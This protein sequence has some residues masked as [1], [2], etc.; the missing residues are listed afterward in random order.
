MLIPKILTYV[1]TVIGL[2]LILV[3]AW[4]AWKRRNPA[5]ATGDDSSR[6]GPV[7]AN[8]WIRGARALFALFFVISVFMHAYWVFWADSNPRFTLAKNLDA[9]NRRLA[10]SGLKGW[11]LDRSA[12]LEN[13][14]IRYR[15]DRGIVSR[16]YPLG[17]AAVHLTGYSDFVFGSGG[18]E[19]AYNDWLTEPVS[20]YNQLVSPVPT[21]NDLTVSIDSSLQRETFALLQRT[22][23][24]AAAVVLLLPNNEVLAMA[25]TPSF[26]PAAV[27]D[28]Q[29]WLRNVDQ[30]NRA[31]QLSPLVN[32]AT[33]TMVTGGPAYYYRPGSTFKTFTAAVAL[34]SGLMNE[35]FV[36]RPEGFVAP[37]V[38]RPI[39]DFEGEV[40]GNIGFEDA[41]KFSCNQYFGQLGI[42][43]GR[44][45]LSNYARR[46]A[47]LIDPDSN[48]TRARD[49]WRINHGDGKDFNF[50]F[51]PPISR[52]N[53]SSMAD[54]YD[55]AL[56]S[57]G[58]GFTDATLIQMAL[59]AATVASQDGVLTPP[60][61]EMGVE[62]KGMVQ[63]ISPQAAAKLRVMMRSVVQSGTA[64]GPFAS[65]RQGLTAGGKTG[66]AERDLIV[67]DRDG[68]P[69]VDKIDLDGRV[70]YKYQRWTDSW[71]IGFAPADEPQIAFAVVVENGG[72]GSRAAAPLAVRLIENAASLGYIARP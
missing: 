48:A 30:A 28:E 15:A 23:R 11:V 34:D 32:R 10:E 46:L 66:T 6:P 39:R 3:L 59:L 51:A 64:A 67:Y 43:L 22:G 21:G 71:F 5:L 60:T 20:T 42:K 45:R 72:P 68:K 4:A 33:G 41:F 16:E 50:I 44:D 56:Q 9:R 35:R 29:A 31:P 47:L 63:F 27:T 24:P 1:V 36:C 14:L 13:A 26:D 57:F 8:R 62:R 61:F 25:S 58:Q 37:G 7:A 18:I 2:L 12:K 19:Y 70:H 40:H 65:L 53:L 17:P 49:Y 69:V 52:L 55:V 54:S 38:T